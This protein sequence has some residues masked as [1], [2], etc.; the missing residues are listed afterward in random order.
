MQKFILRQN[1]AQQDEAVQETNDFCDAINQTITN[2]KANIN[3]DLSMEDLT[4]LVLKNKPLDKIID[5]IQKAALEGTTI[6]L[7]K[8]KIKEEISSEINNSI[9]DFL[10]DF[11]KETED[12]KQM[13]GVAYLSYLSV[14][15]GKVL[16]TPENEALLRDQFRV[17]VTKDTAN[18]FYAKHKAAQAALNDLSTFMWQKTISKPSNF[19]FFADALFSFENGRGVID[20]KDVDYDKMIPSI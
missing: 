19:Q 2:F 12:L 15:D 3:Y 13:P 10:H 8:G 9:K 1:Q 18:D 4:T 7:V 6:N 11:N 16:L 17:Y 5:G 20:M 14:Q